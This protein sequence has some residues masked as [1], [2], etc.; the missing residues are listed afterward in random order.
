MHSKDCDNSLMVTVRCIT[1]NHESYIRQCLEGIVMQRTNFRFEA[2]VHDDASTDRTAAIIKEFAENYPDIIKPIFETENQHSKHNGSLS[3]IMDEHMHG[4]YIAICEGDDY[5]IDPLKLQKQVDVLEKDTS[6]VMSYTNFVSVNSLGKTINKI[7]KRKT[8]TPSGNILPYFVKRNF[9]MALTVMIRSDVYKKVKE[10]L[11]MVTDF[12]VMDYALFWG[13]AYYGNSIYLNDVTSAYRMLDESASH[14]RD[15]G[16]MLS[17]LHNT[18]E[19]KKYYYAKLNIKYSEKKLER[20]L[21]SGYLRVYS[22]L[23]NPSLFFLKWWTGIKHD[24]LNL[25]RL[26]NYAYVLLLLLH[27]K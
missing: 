5:W 7:L 19:I 16:K 25:F 14:S 15:A 20:E 3:R 10:E 26:D 6:S 22:Q 23:N 11:R 9:V 27:K 8:V 1:Y 18:F 2:I 21:V 13:V 12:F 17:F 4:K 24:Y